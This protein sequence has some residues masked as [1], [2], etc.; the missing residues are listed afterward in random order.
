MTR[1]AP[2]RRVSAR[3]NSTTTRVRRRPCRPAELDEERPDSFNVSLKLSCAVC[4]AGAQ[5]KSTPQT[6]DAARLK[7]RTGR[8]KRKSASDGRVKGG[9]M[10]TITFSKPQARLMPRTPPIRDNATLSVKNWAKSCQRVA[11]SAA[12]TAISLWR[13]EP[14]AS[15]RLATFTQAINRDEAD[16][17]HQQPKVLDGVFANEVIP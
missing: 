16:R 2:A 17:A 15:R 9:I 6:I 5:P 3:A 11:P 14:R 8:F 4:Q 13:A 7:N 1:P 12:R 10:A